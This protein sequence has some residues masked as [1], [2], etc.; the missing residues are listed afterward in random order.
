MKHVVS[1]SL[2]SSA[3]NKR[4]E[5][6][7]LGEQF[8]IERIGTDGDKARAIQLIREL[9]GK[10]DAIGLGGIDLYL[11]C[12]GRKY[13]I[14]DAAALA[15][16]ARSTPV[17]DGGGLKHTLERR[18]IRYLDETG[19]V[20]FR[21]T[22]VLLVSGLDRFGMAE[23]LDELGAD[24]VI[25]DLIFAL[26]I[27]IRIHSLNTLDLLARLLMPALSKLPFEM[28]YPTGKQQ[29]KRQTR[30][31][32][33]YDEAQ[34]VAGDFHFIYKYMPDRIDG[35]VIITNTVT[36]RDVQ[37]L[38]E[39]G[40]KMLV[41][42]TPEMDGRSFGTNVLEGVLVAVSGKAPEQLSPEDYEELLD[43]LGFKPRIEVFERQE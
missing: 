36:D 1:V 20:K 3:R 22:R 34:V 32:R 25:G 37:E 16:A 6:E 40:A 7:L 17:V 39:R 4:V 13:V 33:F 14:R 26:G 31:G 29:G 19:I 9:D 42:T 8:I 15:R 41:T 38:K 10:V 23:T 18:V 43:K 2:G 11:R 35:K 27:P 21:G 5:V 24:L 28:L 12:R 30:F